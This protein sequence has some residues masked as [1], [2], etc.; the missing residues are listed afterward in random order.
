MKLEEP[1]VQ[2]R[3]L[4]GGVVQRE[5]EFPC[6]L[7]RHPRA[8]RGERGG[9]R[10]SPTFA[11]HPPTRVALDKRSSEL[12]IL[13]RETPPRETMERVVRFLAFVNRWLGGTAAVARHFRG[14]DGPATV[15]D[16]GAGA[17]D[18]LRRLLIRHPRLRPIAL[19][20]SSMA[21]SFAHGMPRVRG[22]A[23]RLP[24]GDRSVDWVISSHFF[25]HLPDD[26]IVVV[27]REFDRVARRGIV[28]NDLLRNHWAYFWVRLV[29]R[30]ADPIVRFDGPLSVRRAF[31]VEEIESLARR[32]GL[33]WLRVRPF[34]GHRFTLA[35]TR[36]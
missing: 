26:A 10:S 13:D 11:S 25:H 32:A 35:G 27:L 31:T 17:G 7:G 15:L 20:L 33:S 24:F 1:L 36:S 34:L 19:D 22:N 12:E 16:V 8:D 6:F 2:E 23:L 28:V 4:A 21:L 29:T 5:S 14:V 30:F 18:V 9:A 3:D